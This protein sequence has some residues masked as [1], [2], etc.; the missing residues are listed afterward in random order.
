R[1]STSAD[2]HNTA[3][4]LLN[5]MREVLA[6]HK[7]ES[8]KPL[9][10]YQPPKKRPEDIPAYNKLYG[11]SC[12]RCHMLNEAKWEQQRLDGTMKLGAFFLY[13]LPD[14]V[15]IKLD[16]I[17]GNQVVEVVKDSFAEKAG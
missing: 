16:L 5:T 4:G 11:G 10:P 6:L 7:E 17:K 8:A 13:P 2:S 9:P 15:G 14:N 12:G 3:A 1:N